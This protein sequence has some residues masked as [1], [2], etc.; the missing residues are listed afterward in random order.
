MRQCFFWQLQSEFKVA[1]AVLWPSVITK[2]HLSKCHDA[3]VCRLRRCVFLSL[4]IG[5]GRSAPVTLS[6]LSRR[7]ILVAW[8]RDAAE[9]PFAS[10]LL[11]CQRPSRH[12][13]HAPSHLRETA[14]RSL[15]LPERPTDA[16]RGY[17]RR[18]A[19]AE[20]GQT[21][22]EAKLP[23]LSQVIGVRC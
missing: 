21:H 4:L 18:A 14:E 9:G 12:D 20:A 15:R 16:G 1:L 23:A 22:A 13:V 2:T 5:G 17:L 7:R 19:A 8:G 10:A 6:G 3:A 11:V